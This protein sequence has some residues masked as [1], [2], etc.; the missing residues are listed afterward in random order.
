MI[1]AVFF[2]LG[3][4]LWND[5]PSELAYWELVVAELQAH[6]FEVDMP[7][8]LHESA[9][10]IGTFCPSLTRS[11]VWRIVDGDRR[12]YDQVLQA[13]TPRILHRL[14][15]PDEFRSLNP[16]FPG[17]HEML[18]ELANRYSLAVV[19]QNFVEA[20]KWLEFHGI[21]E[22]F[23]HTSISARDKLYKPD[24][25]LFLKT[26]EALGV[27]CR[28]TVMVGDRLDNDIW[29]ANRIGMF[30]AR[31][32]SEPYRIQ[33]PRYHNDVPDLTVEAVAEISELLPGGLKMPKHGTPGTAPGA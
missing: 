15:S 10:V 9:A 3:A 29:P 19:S 8:M 11:I 32:L 13:A 25:R 27:E 6:G 33:Q 1:K 16:L 23:E 4:T 18:E 14:T 24:V 17:V 2:D 26:C 20:E 7:R 30:T 12:I 5:Y 21:E 22:Y 28:E 31:V